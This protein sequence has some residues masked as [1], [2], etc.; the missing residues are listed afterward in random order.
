MKPLL[1]VPRP[2]AADALTQA[3]LDRAARPPGL[4]L[5][6]T[7]EGRRVMARWPR[8]A[9]IQ[10]GEEIEAQ[11]AQVAPL[12]ADPPEG[13]GVGAWRRAADQRD[14]LEGELGAVR[15]LLGRAG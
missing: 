9:L 12:A 4:D 8:A 7:L 11:L 13:T 15:W 10:R 6:A 5:L 1:T 2:P 14:R 3:R